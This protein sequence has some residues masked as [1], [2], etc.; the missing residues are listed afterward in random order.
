[1]HA[2]AVDP[3][4]TRSR[5]KKDKKTIDVDIDAA[6]EFFSFGFI[7]GGKTL[8]RGVELKQLPIPEVNHI[9]NATIDD[10]YKAIVDSVRETVEQASQPILLLS[11][12]IDSR[13][14]A[15]VIAEEKLD[16]PTVTFG[17]KWDKEI[18]E[19]ICRILN[20]RNY[21]VKI[22]DIPPTDLAKIAEKTRGISSVMT[23]A[24]G[25]TVARFVRENKLGTSS[26]TGGGGDEILGGFLHS[27]CSDSKSFYE[28]L[29][30]R[31]RASAIKDLIKPEYLE[32]A[33]D[34]LATFC[35]GLNIDEMFFRAFVN[36]RRRQIDFE[37]A[38]LLRSY[39][40]FVSSYVMSAVYSIP[41]KKR[42]NK[43]PQRRILKKYFPKLYKLRWSW[44]NLP[45][46]LPFKVHVATFY[47]L[48]QIE[49]KFGKKRRGLPFDHAIYLKSHSEFSELVLKN[50]PEICLKGQTKRYITER[51]G[52]YEEVFYRFFTY[53]L[54]FGHL[55][56]VEN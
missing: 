36:T 55:E 40:P 3:D 5:R 45:T 16:V 27:R 47:L 52:E 35:Q 17:S 39:T 30:G 1:M 6:S 22:S 13:I 2:P 43:Q 49:R 42:I 50:L 34:N 37:A 14:L 31:S 8:I 23:Y 46:Y 53:A 12:G 9:K 25:P 32:K 56:G 51:K 7:L 38:G 19:E 54:I 20:L 24:L 41:Y 33:A 4:E 48:R 21:F 28:M 29:I 15:G 10:V 26:I 18:T 44:S 11:G